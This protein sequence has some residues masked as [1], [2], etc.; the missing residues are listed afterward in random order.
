MVPQF[1]QYKSFLHELKGFHGWLVNV[2][3]VIHCSLNEENWGFI[4][5]DCLDVIIKHRE[6]F[7]NYEFSKTEYFHET[8]STS[9]ALL[10]IT[11][12]GVPPVSTGFIDDRT[13][14]IHLWIFFR[15]RSLSPRLFNNFSLWDTSPRLLVSM[16]LFICCGFWI[17]WDTNSKEM[18]S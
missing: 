2:I 6:V 5:H 14:T 8:G 11:F 12:F 15:F 10:I 16:W 17:R 7:W 3:N 13:Y 1:M 4:I 18:K 9:N